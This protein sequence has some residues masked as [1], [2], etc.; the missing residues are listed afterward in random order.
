MKY[1]FVGNGGYFNH[2]D[3]VIEVF[4]AASV[5]NAIEYVREQYSDIN[6][7][8]IDAD[9]WEEL[10]GVTWTAKVKLADETEILWQEEVDVLAPLDTD[11]MSDDE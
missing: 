1:E 5:D 7:E 4:E 3:E 10:E 8:W 6:A 9:G 11:D 2:T